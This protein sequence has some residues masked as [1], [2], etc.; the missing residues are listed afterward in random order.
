VE[1]LGL[2]VTL[3]VALVAIG[4]WV[5]HEVHPPAH[6][7]PVVDAAAWPLTSADSWVGRNVNPLAG[8]GGWRAPR[9]H[10]SGPIGRALRRAVAEA[11]FG[12]GVLGAVGA[13]A[14]DRLA[15]RIRRFV[16]D[17]VGTVRD[18][19]DR[20]GAATSDPVGALA[21]EID[22]IHRYWARVRAKPWRQA[23]RTVAHDLGG[24][25]TDLVLSRARSA[26]RKAAIRHLR[27]RLGERRPGGG[28]PLR[29]V[30]PILG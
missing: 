21:D 17:P 29:D 20:Y 27:R 6:P 3:A 4:A 13:G 8:F 26:V 11:G 30:H 28:G 22:A 5:A 1:H 18:L 7:P 25:G 16:S 24:M 19:V 10:G 14:G 9:G 2:V 12:A 23:V 15:E